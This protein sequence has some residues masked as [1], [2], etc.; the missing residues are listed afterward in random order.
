MEDDAQSGIL[1]Y[2]IIK[3][4]IIRRSLPKSFGPLSK[5]ELN[6]ATKFFHQIA[7][8]K[9]SGELAITHLM[10]VFIVPIYPILNDMDKFKSFG[11]DVSFA[12][13]DNDWL[14]TGMSLI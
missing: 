8:T 6:V 2:L 10:D 14:D 11:V 3:H 5:E 13:G 12:Y 4:R 9:D 1:N 7:L